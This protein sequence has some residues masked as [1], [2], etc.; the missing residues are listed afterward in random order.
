MTDRLVH[1]VD[2]WNDRSAR[3]A[4]PRPPTRPPQAC[5]RNMNTFAFVGD[6]DKG[7]AKVSCVYHSEEAENQVCVCVWCG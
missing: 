3:L 1:W 7:A 2:H 6:L 5:K 4:S